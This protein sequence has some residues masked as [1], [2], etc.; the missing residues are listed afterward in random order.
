MPRASVS[1]DGAVDSGHPTESVNDVNSSSE[2]IGGASHI[3]TVTDPYGATLAASPHLWLPTDELRTRRICRSVAEYGRSRIELYTTP[4]RG[5]YSR[6]LVQLDPVRDADGEV[7]GVHAS[8]IGVG[9][10]GSAGSENDLLVPLLLG[11]GLTHRRT[12]YLFG[13]DYAPIEG[14]SDEVEE[15]PRRARPISAETRNRLAQRLAGGFDLS[16]SCWFLW[17]DL[18]G[19]VIANR[20]VQESVRRVVPGTKA[21]VSSLGEGFSRELARYVARTIEERRGQRF[22]IHCGSGR[23][24]LLQLAPVRRES[25][26]QPTSVEIQCVNITLPDD[27][28]DGTGLSGVTECDFAWDLAPMSSGYS[29]S[30]ER[31]KRVERFEREGRL[32]WERIG[33]PIAHEIPAA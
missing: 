15:R 14:S 5:R 2:P 3:Y 24:A 30:Y 32:V 12:A 33:V 11:G 19:L 22:A 21:F 1:R 29:V 13:D 7:C 9:R 17:D 25:T 4:W 31:R 28:T 23:L 18:D 6:M 20:A 8:G 16:S 27:V 26:S 10:D